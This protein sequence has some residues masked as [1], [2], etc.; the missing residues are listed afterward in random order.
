MRQRYIL[1]HVYKA[2]YRLEIPRELCT[3]N[4]MHDKADYNSNDLRP[5]TE[6]DQF[7]SDN[8]IRFSTHSSYNKLTMYLLEVSEEA[9]MAILLRFDGVKVT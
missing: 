2:K 7:L 9:L 8:Q 3:K 5:I 4:Y 6:L 1:D